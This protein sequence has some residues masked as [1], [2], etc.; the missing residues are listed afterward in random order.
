VTPDEYAIS[1][2]N[3]LIM[4]GRKEIEIS[5]SIM[6]NVSEEGLRE[7][8]RLCRLCGVNYVIRY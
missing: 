5:G 7:I 4:S 6:L 3:R 8:G 1:Y 2:V